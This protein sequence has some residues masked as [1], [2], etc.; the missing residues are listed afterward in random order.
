MKREDSS[1]NLTFY[2]SSL[3][4]SRSG[5][6]QSSSLLTLSRFF[7]LSVHPSVQGALPPQSRPPG[8]AERQAQAGLHTTA[9]HPDGSK[10]SHRAYERFRHFV[11]YLHLRHDSLHST[12]HFLG[13]PLVCLLFARNYHKQKDV[14][15][16][17]T[18]NLLV[19]LCFSECLLHASCCLSNSCRAWAR[20]ALF[21]TRRWPFH[22]AYRGERTLVPC[23]SIAPGFERR[24][25]ALIHVCRRAQAQTVPCDNINVYGSRFSV[26]TLLFH[27]WWASKSSDGTKSCFALNDFDWIFCQHTSK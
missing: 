9:P 1:L 12:C 10:W 27:I 24:I 21:S 2:L 13:C 20:W 16:F 8:W 15:S 14:K 11:G 6:S 26:Q 17:Y 5:A 25:P 22:E 23:T 3:G 7:P 4:N 18:S 19:S